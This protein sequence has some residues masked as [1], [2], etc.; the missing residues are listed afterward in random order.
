MSQ[1]AQQVITPTYADPSNVG[2]TYVNGP[3]NLTVL[4]PCATLTFTVM[5]GD[6]DQMMKGQ[7]QT[8]MTAAVATRLTMPLE[9]A[10]QLRNML[11]QIIQDQPI[12]TIVPGSSRTQ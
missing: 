3:I 5:R 2:E 12:G 9:A 1:I 8:K 6:L 11:N 4:G 7:P 10:A